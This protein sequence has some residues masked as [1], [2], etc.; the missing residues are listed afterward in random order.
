MTIAAVPP[1]ISTPRLPAKKRARWPP[2]RKEKTAKAR[3]SC[4]ATKRMP[5]IDIDHQYH[6]TLWITGILF[7][8]ELR[9]DEENAGYP[10]RQMILVVDVASVC[11]DGSGR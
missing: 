2:S 7:E 3:A 10:Q 11:R 9:C 4:A 8:G 5:V 6:L 1:A